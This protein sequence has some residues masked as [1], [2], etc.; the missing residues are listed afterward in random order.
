MEIVNRSARHDYFVNDTVQC[1]IELRGNEVKSIRAGR[2]N[3]KGSWC[4]VR[5]G[6]LYIIGMH[7]TKWGTEN[8]FDVDEKR[9]VR[10]LAH[11]NEI[12]KMAEEVSQMGVSLIPLKLYFV[13]GRV[14]ADIGICTGKK[15]YDKRQTLRERTIDRSIQREMRGSL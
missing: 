14:K 12:R 13:N 10:L 9:D 5:D 15:L 2:V 8:D 4:L 11:K 6:Q 7:I 1:G 3:L